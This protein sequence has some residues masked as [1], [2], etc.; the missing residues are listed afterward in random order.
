MMLFEQS[1]HQLIHIVFNTY[2]LKIDSIK[3]D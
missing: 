2:K 1:N 3:D